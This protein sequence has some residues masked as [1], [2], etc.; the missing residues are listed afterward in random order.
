M[1]LYGASR[2]K[3][4]ILACPCFLFSFFA[5]ANNVVSFVELY[6]IN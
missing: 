5:F 6:K 3:T 1:P 4:H 2:K